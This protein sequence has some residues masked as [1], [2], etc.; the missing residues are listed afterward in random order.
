MAAFGSA[1]LLTSDI[2]EFPVEP[3]FQGETC[4]ASSLLHTQ[5]HFSLTWWR[6]VLELSLPLDFLVS[7]FGS[8]VHFFLLL[9]FAVA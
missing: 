7:L 6:E 3:L 8:V 9:L 2:F 1:T 4:E 5:A